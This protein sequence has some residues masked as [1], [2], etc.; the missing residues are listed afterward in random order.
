VAFSVL[1]QSFPTEIEAT[2]AL[3]VRAPYKSL[4]SPRTRR[5]NLNVIISSVSQK[6][7]FAYVLT[8]SNMPGISAFVAESMEVPTFH[9]ATIAKVISQNI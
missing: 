1:F 4:D 9:V 6:L 5:T 8:L 2:V 3:H 7:L